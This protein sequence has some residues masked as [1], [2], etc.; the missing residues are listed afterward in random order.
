MDPVT[1]IALGGAVAV[2]TMGR[3]TSAWRAAA[4]GALA[5]ALPDVDVFIDHGNPV[6]DMVLHRAETHALFWLSL[7][8]L[9]F[10]WVVAR[11]HRETA[12]WSRWWCALWLALVT[13]PLLDTLTV[14]GTQLALPFSDH[15]FGTGSVAIIDPLFTLPL[16]VGTGMALAGR[17]QRANTI[18]LVLGGAYLAWGLA[19]QQHV[20][21]VAA[22]ALG[23]QG[24]AAERVLVTPTVFNSLLWRVLVVQG[25]HSHEGFHSL[26][27]R[28]PSIQFERFDRGG[29]ALAAEL[30]D[31]DAV[32]RIAAF[33]K[34]FYALRQDGPRV[35]LTDLRM[36]L[37]PHY[38]FRFVVAERASPPV[39]LAVPLQV[40]SRPDL[41]VALP[42]LWRR[43]LG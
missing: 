26:L 43:A 30:R 37:E 15:P 32:R 24:I 42:W 13:H 19:A 27:D 5:G 14:Y 38:S 41:G 33:S 6:H 20:T 39:P 8:S 10:A 35:L 11:L 1:Q 29:Q 25:E 31:V 23:A 2:A 7:A 36:G 22:A 9:P 16:L 4:W 28:D 40:G 18:G 3:R 21:R 12:H 34:G 17:R